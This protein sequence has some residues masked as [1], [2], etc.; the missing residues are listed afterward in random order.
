MPVP[1]RLLLEPSHQNRGRSPQG[2]RKNTTI[3]VSSHAAG[4]AGV[5]AG[6]R[7]W[8]GR[9]WVT[10][11]V[12][13][14]RRSQHATLAGAGSAVPYATRL[15]RAGAGRTA[16]GRK[17]TWPRDRARGEPAQPLHRCQT[18][19]QELERALLMSGIA[20]SGREERTAAP[21][22][23]SRD[24]TRGGTT[25]EMMRM[26]AAYAILPWNCKIRDRTM[27]KCG[28]VFLGEA[29]LRRRGHPGT[30]RTLPLVGRPVPPC[31]SGSKASKS[32]ETRTTPPVVTQI[33]S[34]VQAA[35]EVRPLLGAPTPPVRRRTRRHEQG[36][37]QQ[38]PRIMNTYSSHG[39]SALSSL[40]RY[41]H[42]LCVAH[43]LHR[44]F[45]SA[46]ASMARAGWGWN[47]PGYPS[48]ISP[49][50]HC[51]GLDTVGRPCSALGLR[52]EEDD[53]EPQSTRPPRRWTRSQATIHT[54]LR[55]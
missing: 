11:A 12:W 45:L 9:P 24:P 3:P 18:P 26:T 32:P 13:S 48:T 10:R 23:W 20:P 2:W 7:G 44:E 40:R 25:K 49:C 17:G 54:S 14:Q 29:V 19:F 55:R 36:P 21:R 31:P 28:Y 16:T 38:M 30:R 4:A 22:C 37:R 41:A 47:S 51:P 53:R 46:T 39:L 1:P 33:E 52:T 42:R 8:T 5:V 15:P 34:P 50:L 43:R 35:R 6:D 27:R